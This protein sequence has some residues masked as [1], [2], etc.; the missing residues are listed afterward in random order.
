MS[1]WNF[2]VFLCSVISGPT[3]LW[4]EIRETYYEAD[5]T[6]V[7]GY[8]DVAMDAGGEDLAWLIDAMLGALAKPVLCVET[9][10]ELGGYAELKDRIEEIN[11]ADDAVAAELSSKLLLHRIADS[12]H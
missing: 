5:R 9:G 6:T 11:R 10:T 7:Q 2:R 8:S 3:E 4:F 1:S 12:K